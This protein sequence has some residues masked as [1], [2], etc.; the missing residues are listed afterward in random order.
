MR[1]RSFIRT[2]LDIDKDRILKPFRN[3]ASDSYL[4][5]REQQFKPAYE[6]HE[7]YESQ[8]QFSHLN[9]RQP[10]Q[11]DVE[12][13]VEI[14]PAVHTPSPAQPPSPQETLPLEAEHDPPAGEYD[15]IVERFLIQRS[16]SD[17]GDAASI[18]DSLE[19]DMAIEDMSVADL[20]TELDAPLQADEPMDEMIDEPIAD[21]IYDRDLEMILADPFF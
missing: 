6:P 7:T 18:G 21:D 15:P 1:Y 16:M 13:T 3:H 20:D 19:I 17:M 10:H 14:Q 5:Q 9:Q 4:P 11:R 12:Q 2:F 8:V